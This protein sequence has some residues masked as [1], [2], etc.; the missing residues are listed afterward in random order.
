MT[1]NGPDRV[2]LVHGDNPNWSIIWLH[3]LGADGHDFEPVAA[4]LNLPDSVSVRFVFP[5]APYRSVTINGGMR[6]RAWYD[7][8]A[9]ELDSRADAAGVEESTQLLKGWVEEEISRGIDPSHII[10]AGFSQGGAIA[11]NIALKLDQKVA[12]I[13]ALST[14]IPSPVATGTEVANA[15]IPLFMGH[16]QFDPVVSPALG[17]AARQTMIES[18]FDVTW[19]TYPMPHSVAPEEIR[20]IRNWLGQVLGFQ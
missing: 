7:I 19:Q 10:L 12:G 13:I 1:Q 4:A 6:M 8:R 11:L 14:Y 2:E 15:G 3:G 16:G 9:M 18:G 17:E 20:D 5:H